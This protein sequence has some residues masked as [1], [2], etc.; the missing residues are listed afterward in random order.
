[1]AEAMLSAA[2]E[3]KAELSGVLDFSSVPR[4]WPELKRVIE[5][6]PQL[7]LSLAGVTS[8]NSAALALL[9][10][11][12]QLSHSA[13]RPLV[14]RDVPADLADLAGLSNLSGVLGT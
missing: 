11:A 12:V 8:S 10:E 4:I 2:G 9:L 13:Q 7:E 6:G 1:M 3:G 14:L 5:R